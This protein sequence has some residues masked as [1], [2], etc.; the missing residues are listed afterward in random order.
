[1]T[2]DKI[3]QFLRILKRQALIFS[4]QNNDKIDVI[5]QCRG[6][7]CKFG[8]CGKDYVEAFNFRMQ[9]SKDVKSV[10]EF[11]DIHFCCFFLALFI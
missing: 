11:R 8:C 7:F 6:F 4:G 5:V 9:I 2:S 10:K 3:K 1:M